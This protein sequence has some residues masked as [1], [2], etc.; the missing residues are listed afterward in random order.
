MMQFH[1]H[2]C[3]S[4]LEQQIRTS[5]WSA[6]IRLQ[7]QHPITPLKGNLKE[8]EYIVVSMS[9]LIM[10]IKK[11]VIIIIKYITPPKHTFLFLELALILR[12][13]HPFSE[14]QAS[15]LSLW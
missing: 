14:L 15:I 8:W 1:F 2:S 9:L 4:F 10:K 3:S 12:S 6:N 7:P 11:C 5:M 13:D